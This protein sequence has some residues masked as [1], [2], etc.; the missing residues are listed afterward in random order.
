MTTCRYENKIDDY[1]LN[2]LDAEDR[3]EFEE[4]YFNCPSCF[5][6][7]EQRQAVIFIIKAQ[8]EELLG[9]KASPA[10]RPSFKKQVF[11]SLSF[12]PKPVMAFAAAASLCLV[13][14]LG[15]LPLMKSSS[16]QFYVN[17]DV[18]RGN[19]ITLISPVISVD[20]VPTLFM[21][22]PLTD[23][24]E[25]RIYVYN[26]KLLWTESTRESSIA[27]PIRI[28]AKM[29]EGQEYSWQV[30]AFSPEGRLVSVSSLVYFKFTTVGQN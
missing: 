1:L 30:K 21:W 26:G 22:R 19:S 4:H 14:F 6:K 3:R 2:K 18:V 13:A 24:V 28:Q 20:E 27:L 11:S 29:K 8:G 7:L 12:S 23:D 5:E 15:V 16:P 10:P 17:E 9:S 25:Y